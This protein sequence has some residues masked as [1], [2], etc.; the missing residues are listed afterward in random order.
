MRTRRPHAPSARRRALRA[1]AAAALLALAAR[2]AAAQDHRLEIDLTGG[3]RF[4]IGD[5][6]RYARPGFDD[7]E[8]EIVSVPTLWENQGFPGYD[9]FAW[10]RLEIKIPRNLRG[11]SLYLKLGR[12]DDVDRTYFNGTLIGGEG[13]FPPQ[14]RTAWDAK[15]VYRIP[16]ECI[17]FGERNVIAVR[18][19]DM[20]RGGGIVEGEVGVY[21]RPEERPLDVCLNGAWKFAVGDDGRWAS[22]D[23]NDASWETQEVPGFWESHGHEEYNGFAWY[24]RSVVLPGSHRKEKLILLLGKIDD[25]DQT[26]FNGVLIGQTGA[27]GR[28]GMDWEDSYRAERAY[29]IPEGLVRPD[30]ANV[31]AVRVLDTGGGGGLY[32]GQV[33]IVTREQYLEYQERNKR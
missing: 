31:I 12:I 21:S 28:N 8:W 14:I 2:P 3:W 33:G 19:F 6:M 22:P 7:A 15:R 11:R 4:S 10:Y 5:D 20:W 30:R 23:W 18:V 25:A 17:R 26:F 29:F 24:R 16:L 27:F 13:E 32:E 9:G 1:A